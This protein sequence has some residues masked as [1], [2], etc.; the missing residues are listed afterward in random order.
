M[1]SRVNIRR[2]T[3]CITPSSVRHPAHPPP[4]PTIVPLSCLTCLKALILMSSPPQPPSVSGLGSA[5]LT[6]LRTSVPTMEF[7]KTLPHYPLFISSPL[8]S[9]HIL[10]K[11]VFTYKKQR[12][13]TGD[14]I[15]LEVENWM[16]KGV[17]VEARDGEEAKK[18]AKGKGFWKNRGREE[19]F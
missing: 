9:S 8:S 15:K 11:E 16:D 3:S 19:F 13:S 10:V 6:M 18:K 17:Y 2:F 4:H 12:Y 7:I 5:P 14:Y 1:S